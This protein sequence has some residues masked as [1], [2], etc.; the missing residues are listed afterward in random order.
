MDVCVCVDVCGCVCMCV[1]AR[2]R[3]YMRVV[4]IAIHS[5][6]NNCTVK[7]EN[8]DI[9]DACSLQTDMIFIP[10]C[11]SP[12]APTLPISVDYGN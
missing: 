6:N 8:K 4:V 10:V 3:A 7:E 2:A 11:L 5:H 12:H 1:S 9:M